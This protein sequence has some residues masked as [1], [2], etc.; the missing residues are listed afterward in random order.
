[1][2]IHSV[3]VRKSVS[4][5]GLG[6][7][8]VAIDY[9]FKAVGITKEVCIPDRVILVAINKRDSFN[10]LLI[11]L[12]AKCVENLSENLRS[13]LKRAKGVSVLEKAFGIKSVLPDD[14]TE[15]SDNL[16][17]EC[18]MLSSRL[19]SA[20]GSGSASFTDSSVEVLLE[21]LLCEDLVNFIREFSPVNMSAFFW[22]LKCLAE[23]LKLLLR[24]RSLCHRQTNAELSS[25]DM[26]GAK[27][28]KVTEEL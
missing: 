15:V 1:M 18:G 4:E 24:D 5:S 23:Q 16:L 11:N 8:S 6:A 12:E 21:T 25:C 22:G 13:H 3:E 14:F 2:V 20:I 26:T 28:I 27:S 17:A 10:L 9:V 19:A 7:C